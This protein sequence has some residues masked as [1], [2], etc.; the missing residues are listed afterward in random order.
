MPDD[1][2]RL[3]PLSRRGASDRGGTPGALGG[4]RARAQ[5]ISSYMHR[6]RMAV[7]VASRQGVP[8]VAHQRARSDLCW[9]YR[10]N[11]HMYVGLYMALYTCGATHVVHISVRRLPYLSTVRSLIFYGAACVWSQHYGDHSKRSS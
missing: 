3:V 9:N 1:R 5:A 6:V 8:Q 10:I 11:R 7:A 4:A 2:L